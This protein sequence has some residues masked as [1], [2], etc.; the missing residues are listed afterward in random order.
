MHS[1]TAIPDAA[2]CVVNLEG[3]DSQTLATIGWQHVAPN[4]PRIDLCH[5][6]GQGVM[7][8][9]LLNCNGV[10]IHNGTVAVAVPVHEMIKL[11][12]R[13]APSLLITPAN[14]V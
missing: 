4:Q 12:L 2:H 14:P 5:D 11:A 10:L 13:V 3:F 1:R 8:D 9:V 7:L 6:A